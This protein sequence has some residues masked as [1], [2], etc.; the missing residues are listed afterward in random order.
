MLIII[1]SNTDRI[2]LSSSCSRILESGDERLIDSPQSCQ[3][4]K[5]ASSGSIQLFTLLILYLMGPVPRWF[6]NFHPHRGSSNWLHVTSGNFLALNV[7]IHWFC[8]FIAWRLCWDCR[9]PWMGGKVSMSNPLVIHEV[10][11]ASEKTTSATSSEESRLRDSMNESQRLSCVCESLCAGSMCE[12]RSK[13]CVVC[14]ECSR[15]DEASYD[16]HWVSEDM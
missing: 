8:F 13:F 6:Y 4:Q 9:G 12:C 2:I 7:G 14:W 1:L 16:L 15:A 10:N 11:S 5:H 3:S